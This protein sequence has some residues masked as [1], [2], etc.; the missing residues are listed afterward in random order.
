MTLDQW[1]AYLTASLVLG[2][3]FSILTAIY[4]VSLVFMAGK[5][6]KKAGQNAMVQ[7]LAKWLGGLLMI[8]FGLRLALVSHR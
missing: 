6:A 7:S 8:G 5:L 4:Y 1:L 2:T 3:A